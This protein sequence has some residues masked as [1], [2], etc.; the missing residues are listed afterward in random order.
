M[1]AGYN[2]YNGTITTVPGFLRGYRAWRLDPYAKQLLPLHVNLGA[3]LRGRNKAYCAADPEVSWTP[4]SGSQGNRIYHLEP[5]RRFNWQTP[6]RDCSCGFYASYTPETYKHQVS[7]HP[8]CY[9]VN[10]PSPV[11][12]GCMKATGRVVLGETG[13]RAGIGEI[14]ALWGWGARSIAKKYNVPWFLTKYQFLKKYPPHSVSALLEECEDH[15]PA[16]IV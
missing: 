14:E 13:F 6:G 12:H 3:W 1:T 16:N 15:G 2:C 10:G 9:Y 5:G 8:G 7:K 4:S 11:I